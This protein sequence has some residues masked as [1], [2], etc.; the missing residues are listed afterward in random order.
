MS[1]EALVVIAGPA[2][3]TRIPVMAE[4]VIGRAEA[5]AG[6]LGDDTA[7]SRLHA[8]VVNTGTG[9]TIEDLGS[10]NGTE[11][12]GH[13]ISAVTTLIPGDRITVGTSTLRVDAATA[14]A[15]ARPTS[16][17]APRAASVAPFEPPVVRKRS[18]VVSS[19]TNL[20]VVIAAL[21]IIA[22]IV[23]TRGTGGGGGT[24][25]S[26]HLTPG[27]DGT[28]Y[29]ESNIALPGRN[30]ILAMR[31]H[32][33]SFRPMQVT[34]YLTGG[35]GSA[36]LDDRGVLDADQ[37]LITN[38]DHTL[39][40]G[41]N[42]GSDTVAVFHIANDGVLTPVNGSPFASGGTAP[43]SLGIAGKI[44]I[45]ANKA[46]DGVRDLAAVKPNY[47]TMQIDG[48]G[49]LHPTGHTIEAEP[50]ASPTQVYVAAAGSLV[51]ATE[52]S[53]TTRAFKLG[54]DGSLTEATGSPLPLPDS[55]FTTGQ[56]RPSPVWPAG[57]SVNPAAPIL[58][59]GVPNYNSILTIDYTGD[60]VMTIDTGAADPKAVLPCWSV[61]SAD[62]TRLYF[63]NAGSDNI[64][65]WDLNAN[66]QQPQLLQTVP[67]RGG[68]NPWNLVIDPGG[69]LIYIIT[70]RQVASLV[71]GGQ[72]QLLHTL[73]IGGDGTLTETSDSPVPLPASLDTNPIGLAIAPAR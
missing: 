30:S 45:V 48:D 69:T 11:V 37:Q 58:Y 47:T 33:G 56:P 17:A 26:Q 15:A 73:A 52:E 24:P 63:A 14:V 67:L 1:G 39:L 25:S 8:R 7:L 70:P 40:F 22:V 72:G 28:A 54:S 65:V 55:L 18:P 35:A 12:N 64:S 13:R 59:T 2:S 43:G 27:V 36:D 57:L 68:G 71:P 6:S 38:A 42:Q 16:E 20:V 49:A 50:K 29:V 60:G 51:F 3:G 21:V 62:G 31:Y 23:A 66:P 61:V 4:L 32:G 41:I 19:R 10:S 46:H 9:L 5:G 53:G 34:E 44:L